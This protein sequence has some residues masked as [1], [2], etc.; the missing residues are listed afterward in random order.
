[1]VDVYAGGEALLTDFKPGTLTDPTAL[2]A[3]DYDL[4]VVA[5]GDGPDGKAIMDAGG[6]GVPVGA[7]ITVV[8]H[9][10]ECG[11]PR[12]TPY[13]NDTSQVAAGQARLTVR[14]D[15]AA[16]AVDVRAGGN[17]VLTDLVNRMRTVPTSP[18]ARSPPRWCSPAPTRWRS[19]PP[20]STWPRASTRSCTPGAAPRTTTQARRP[21]D[22]RH[23]LRAFRRAERHRWSGGRRRR[24][25]ASGDLRRCL[26]S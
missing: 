20:T 8:D 24:R 6:V 4:N 21:D 17:P 23:A 9:L 1:V 15:A 10:D 13:V 11:K 16:P 19:V 22:Q 25:L 18:P 3:G 14:H 7:N 12:L 5:A 26:P 2:P